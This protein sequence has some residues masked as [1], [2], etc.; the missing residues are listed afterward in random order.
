LELLAEIR[1]EHGMAMLMITHD[2]GVVAE[3]ADRVAV[4]YGGQV[5]ET[6]SVRDVLLH[7]RHPYTQALIETMPHAYT[8][9]GELRVIPGMVPTPANWPTG[10]RFSSRCAHVVDRCRVDT[11][12]L[13]GVESRAEVRCLRIDELA[14]SGS[15]L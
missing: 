6:G 11:P 12:V 5:M 8:G 13:V 10:C 14:D 3:V 4:M 7:P 1:D 15:R 9:V 2:V